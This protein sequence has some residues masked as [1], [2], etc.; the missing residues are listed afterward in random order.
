MRASSI[1]LC[2][3]SLASIS[4]GQSL[5]IRFGTSASTPSPNYAAAGLPG[6][7]NSLQITPEYV[8]EP[9]VDLQGNAVAAQYYQAGNAST[10]TFNN[11]LTSGDDKKLMDS[12]IL[13]TNNPTDG[14]FWVQG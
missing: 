3:C 12:M 11:P 13:S 7:W 4:I 14:C 2:V 10:F 1:A 9:L 6:V 8:L 5:N